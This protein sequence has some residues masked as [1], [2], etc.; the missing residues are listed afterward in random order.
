MKLTSTFYSFI[1]FYLVIIINLKGQILNDPQ[2]ELII[3][4]IREQ[5]GNIS[6]NYKFGL[7]YNNITINT[8]DTL[9]NPDGFFYVFKLKNGKIE[10]LDNSKFHG[11]NF[12]RTLFSW[13]D[14]MYALG[15]YGMFTTNNNL[16]MFNPYI[17]EWSFVETIGEKPNAI[18]GCS[19]KNKSNIYSFNNF[20]SGN[21]TSKDIFDPNFYILNLN[22]MVWN[23][24]ELE[25]TSILLKGY[26]YATK[27]YL[28]FFGERQSILIKPS[29]LEYVLIKNE[30]QG[31]ITNDKIIGTS[32]DYL[33][34]KSFGSSETDTIIKKI[35]VNSI[36][37]K[38]KNKIKKFTFKSK[39]KP[40]RTIFIL[41]TTIILITSTCFLYLNKRKIKKKSK[42]TSFTDLHL[43]LIEQ[44][45]VMLST[46]ELDEI[47]EISHLEMDSKKLKRHR[48]INDLNLNHP[49]FISRIKDENDKRKFLYMIKKEGN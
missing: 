42:A 19:F 35:S 37:K 30:N 39:K 28:F 48:I 29:T 17:K 5:F 32:N 15:G 38:S 36:W 16:I 40:N 4:T 14:N 45:K 26:N 43:K 25:D 3:E 47:L 10:R 9:Y 31:I 27:N 34:V 11:A 41:V 33:K 49:N 1:F 23:S 20:K 18:L 46:D 8:S 21:S 22:S 24:Y 44:E 7:T 13:K 12:M 6:N 2:K